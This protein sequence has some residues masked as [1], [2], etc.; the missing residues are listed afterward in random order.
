MSITKSQFPLKYIRDAIQEEGSQLSAED[1]LNV[2]ENIKIQTNNH[3]IQRLLILIE[4]YVRPSITRAL[5]CP[6]AEEQMVLDTQRMNR[7]RWVD[8]YNTV[9]CEE[10]GIEGEDLDR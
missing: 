4:G 3:D 10:T 7:I 6:E 1:I 2:I 8:R 5:T 9:A